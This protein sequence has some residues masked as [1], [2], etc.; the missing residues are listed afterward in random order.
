M[1]TNDEI[2]SRLLAQAT[3]ELFYDYSFEVEHLGRVCEPAR[4]PEMAG[5]IG[6]FGSQLTGTL[7]LAAGENVI[8]AQ[9][10]AVPG[11]VSAT[12]WVAELSN[13][14]LGRLKHLLLRHSATVSLGIPVAVT[15]RELEFKSKGDSHSTCHL[16]RSRCGTVLVW[17]DVEFSEG[18]RFQLRPDGEPG[19]RAGDTVLF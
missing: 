17:M 14:L 8:R 7:A 16:F 12:D 6:F 5:M 11:V 13:Q 19:P 4:F 9:A 1:T 3:T 2:L 18:F 15:G 10:A